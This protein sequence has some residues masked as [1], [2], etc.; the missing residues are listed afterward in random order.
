M[1][2]QIYKNH[3]GS[4]STEEEVRATFSGGEFESI[5]MTIPVEEELRSDTGK[6]VKQAE[7]SRRYILYI[8]LA[9]VGLVA[10]NE[11][12]VDSAKPILF[13]L[14]LS[15]ILLSSCTVS[16]KRRRQKW[17]HHY[18][19][20]CKA[21]REF[22]AVFE[23]YIRVVILGDREIDLPPQPAVSHPLFQKHDPVI[24][25]EDARIEGN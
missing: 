23:D 21:R 8:V 25:R 14:A 18:R 10:Y 12:L 19:R 11:F 22:D 3:E 2:V 6:S 17:L 9:G 1:L 16:I 24:M 20:F 7:S 5:Q 15:M 13:A 4:P